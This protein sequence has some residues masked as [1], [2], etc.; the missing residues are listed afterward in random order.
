MLR[1]GKLET[2]LVVVLLLNALFFLYIGV[3]V[4][5]SAH[6]IFISAKTFFFFL[7][8]IIGS[9]LI[10]QI[11]KQLQSETPVELSIFITPI[12]SFI[13]L[14]YF[15]FQMKG[16]IAVGVSDRTLR[17]AIN[18]SLEVNKLKYEDLMTGT[19]LKDVNAKLDVSIQDW[20]ATGQVK[21][22]SIKNKGLL[23]ALISGVNDFYR[24]KAIEANNDASYSYLFFSAILLVFSFLIAR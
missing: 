1:K 11:D 7:S 20:V 19:H 18:Y 23:D 5:Y 17:D 10:Y 15:W 3:K 6:P 24:T 22:H 14:S 9:I 4:F 16:Y 2:C 13:V 8:M 21:V 12:M